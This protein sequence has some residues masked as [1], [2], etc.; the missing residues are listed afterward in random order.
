[1]DITLELLEI[2]DAI[3]RRG[4][5]AAAAEELER[6]PSAL[7]YSIQKYEERLG[8]RIFV[9]EGRRSVF[10]PVGRCLL[11][12]GRQLLAAASA[13]SEE[14]QTLASGWEPRLK[15][16]VDSL[17]P[18]DEVMLTISGFL[19]QH[20]GI[21]I[22]IS[23]EVLGGAWEAGEQAADAARM[24]LVDHAGVG[25]VLGLLALAVPLRQM[26]LE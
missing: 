7:S 22:D 25:R 10:T 12:R 21:E 9:R 19:A 2:L 3:E 14:V 5:F 23:E 20:P 11:E 16:A 26:L 18:M 4:S 6:V 8:A 13:L 15:I 17:M 24:A 1:M